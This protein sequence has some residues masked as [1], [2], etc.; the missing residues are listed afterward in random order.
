MIHRPQQRREGEAEPPP[1]QRHCPLREAEGRPDPERGAAT[2]SRCALR[3]RGGEGVHEE[4]EGEEEKGEH[5][6][7]PK[8]GG[9]LEVKH[10]T[11]DRPFMSE[12]RDSDILIIGAGHNALTC[13]FYLAAARAEGDDARGART[14]SAARR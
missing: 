10:A 8:A 2:G 6:R 9:G 1:Q 5:R 11:G 14:S 13:A 4:G 3:E 7:G 12:T